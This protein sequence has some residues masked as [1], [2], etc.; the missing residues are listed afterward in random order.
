MAMVS[1]YFFSPKRIIGRKIYCNEL[2]E[3]LVI[4]HGSGSSTF[5]DDFS[6]NGQDGKPR[7]S[8]QVSVDTF[9]T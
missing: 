8:E 5:L 4:K 3:L 1:A 7:G 2:E 9:I 6:I